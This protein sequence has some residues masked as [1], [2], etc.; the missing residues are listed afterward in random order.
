MTESR[1]SH[2]NMKCLPSQQHLGERRGHTSLADASQ[3]K[4]VSTPHFVLKLSS[5][6][7]VNTTVQF[8]LPFQI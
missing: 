4:R 8:N 2:V 6:M 7:N 5:Y 3:C 1:A